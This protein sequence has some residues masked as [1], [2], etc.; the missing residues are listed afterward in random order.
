MDFGVSALFK[1]QFILTAQTGML[2][3]SFVHGLAGQDEPGTGL[4]DGVVSS[5][6]LGYIVLPRS[7]TY[8]TCA[9]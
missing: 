9:H 4:Y 8:I 7:G 5:S 6:I 1:A 2:S 3:I